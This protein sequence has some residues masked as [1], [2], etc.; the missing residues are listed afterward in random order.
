MRTEWDGDLPIDLAA[1]EVR[2]IT[3]LANP[4]T[5]I[6]QPRRFR[7]VL[8]DR[9][10][11]TRSQ[12]PPNTHVAER[13][14]ERERRTHLR[15]EAA[16]ASATLASAPRPRC[17]IHPPIHGS[18]ANEVRASGWGETPGV[19]AEPSSDHTRHHPTD[20]HASAGR[21]PALGAGWHRGTGSS[22]GDAGDTPA[23]VPV[24]GWLELE[25]SLRILVR[26]WRRVP[27][28]RF[29]CFHTGSKNLIEFLEGFLHPR[30]KF[31]PRVLVQRI[32]AVLEKKDA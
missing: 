27:V 7:R 5:A 6:G 21:T 11:W 28:G 12:S 1:S 19:R 15:A 29:E 24:G 3:S 22:S 20:H 25:R 2:G 26:C 30:L 9:R 13:E 14:R 8:R 31:G 16:R 23:R 17:R 18:F 10:S 32:A 4:E